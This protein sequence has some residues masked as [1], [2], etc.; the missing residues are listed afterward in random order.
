MAAF[1]VLGV[2][3]G[4]SQHDEGRVRCVAQR[5]IEQAQPEHDFVGIAR[6]A[7]IFGAVENGRCCGEAQKRQ[8]GTGG[9]HRNDPMRGRGEALR[10]QGVGR[11]D[12]GCAASREVAPKQRRQIARFSDWE[13][14]QDRHAAIAREPTKALSILSVAQPSVLVQV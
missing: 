11:Q 5:A 10:S 13:A 9:L 4:P 6:A 2:K 3:I 14:G 12:L 1:P 7:P 8:D